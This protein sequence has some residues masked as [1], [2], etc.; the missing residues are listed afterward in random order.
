MKNTQ[1][2]YHAYLLRFWQVGRGRDTA[3]RASLENPRTGEEKRFSSI[4]DMHVFLE[5]QMEADTSSE[6]GKQNVS[7]L[8]SDPARREL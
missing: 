1:S 8:Y 4:Q 3:W 6:K 5:E 2:G 7:K